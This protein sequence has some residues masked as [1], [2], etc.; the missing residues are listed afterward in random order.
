VKFPVFIFGTQRSGTTLLSRV[1]SAHPKVI[2]Q[3]ETTLKA[4]FGHG[5]SKS[6]LVREIASRVKIPAGE[7]L[8]RVLEKNPGMVWG[9][10][11]PQLTEY[12]GELRQ[13]LG[14]S[15]FIIIIRDGR[16]VANSYIENRWGLGT[17]VYTGAMRWKREVEAQEAFIREKPEDFL[18]IRYEDLV[19]N[20]ETEMK[21]VCK[22]IGIEFHPDILEYYR[23]QSSYK[24][25]P[26]NIHSY[27]KPDKALSEKWKSKLSKY[28]IGVIECVADD[29]LMRYGYTLQGN[30]VSVGW[31][32][33]VYYQIH[34]LIIGELQLQY[35]WRKS[36]HKTVKN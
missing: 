21:K 22:H 8:E 18:Q 27:S 13:F 11:D 36:K 15:K 4:I 23:K 19:E 1:L 30:K 3:N 7:T 17:N 28:Q 2:I 32:H 5:Y 26:E 29:V 34:Q 12:I 10:K 20:L 25:R 9:L 31:M 33:R 24:K 16:A 6:K 14:D 35:Q